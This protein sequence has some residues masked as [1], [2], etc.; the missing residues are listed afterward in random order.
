[1]AK[2]KIEELKEGK[3]YRTKDLFFKAEKISFQT[4]NKVWAIDY[5]PGFRI[6]SGSLS[7]QRQNYE[8]YFFGN[9]IFEEIDE[10]VFLRTAK[11]MEMVWAVTIARANTEL[12][13]D[14]ETIA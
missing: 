14:F 11:Q 7:F 10:D 13:G 9:E 6:D 4:M 8:C 12:K 2:L 3:C 5:A 1:M